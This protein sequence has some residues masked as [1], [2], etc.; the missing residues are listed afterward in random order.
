KR[1]GDKLELLLA[2]SL[3]VAHEA[4]ALRSQDLKRVTDGTT[5]QPKATSFPND[6]K[7]LHAAIKGLNRLATRHGVRLRQSY[8]RVAKA[9]AMMASRYAHAKQFRRHQ[10]QLPIVRSR[11]GRIIRDVRRKIEGQAALEE[12]FVLPLGR[13]T[14]IRSQQQRQRG[15]KLY[16]SHA[17]ELGCIGKGKAS[18]P[19]E[20]VVKASVTTPNRRAPG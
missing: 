18:A 15:F 9:A 3:R 7:L 16:S 11:L 14:Q 17:P 2:E 13:A 5:G 10:R 8:S 4:G 1:L 12:A 19:Y 20:L 6:A